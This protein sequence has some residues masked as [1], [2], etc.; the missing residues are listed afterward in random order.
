MP[1]PLLCFK[2]VLVRVKYNRETLPEAE[3]MRDAERGLLQCFDL[4]SLSETRF[5][6]KVTNQITAVQILEDSL[7]IRSLAVGPWV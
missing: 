6:R 1:S 3:G 5:G 4:C 2:L 7:A